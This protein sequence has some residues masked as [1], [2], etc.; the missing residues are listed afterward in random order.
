MPPRPLELADGGLSVD[1]SH[2]ESVATMLTSQ[3]LCEQDDHCMKP[4]DLKELRQLE[5]NEYCIDCGEPN[6][7]WAS[8]T[9]GVFMCLECSGKHRAL[10]THVSKVRSVRMDSWSEEIISLM[11][12]GGNKDCVKFLKKHGLRGSH[13]IA[14]RYD[15]AAGMLYQQVLIARRDGLPEPTEMPDYTPNRRKSIKSLQGFGSQHNLAAERTFEPS[16]PVSPILNNIKRISLNNAKA[17]GERGKQVEDA[18][19]N[20]T[21]VIGQAVNALFRLSQVKEPTL[22]E[23]NH[24]DNGEEFELADDI[25]KESKSLQSFGSISIGTETVSSVSEDE[26]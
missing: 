16:S 23:S 3:S 20:N 9:L 1:Y 26:S 24:G 12:C 7:E 6:P 17:L 22:D 13:T 11:K 10:G 21:K 5:G 4:S 18:L 15:C 2:Q 8:I 19:K 25:V 14:E